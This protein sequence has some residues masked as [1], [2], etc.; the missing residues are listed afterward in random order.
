MPGF[1]GVA[2][3]FGA[4]M[5]RCARLL[6]NYEAFDTTCNQSSITYELA[7]RRNRI[8]AKNKQ[9]CN[10]LRPDGLYGRKYG[11]P[12]AHPG[13]DIQMELRRMNPARLLHL[14]RLF[15]YHDEQNE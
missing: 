6:H 1:G 7:L 13:G 15:A 9:H 12:N 10:N 11:E 5:H 4:G 3:G 8:G 14:L 2:E